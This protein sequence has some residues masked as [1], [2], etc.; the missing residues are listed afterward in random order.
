[1]FFYNSSDD[2]EDELECKEDSCS[3]T[4]ACIK[5]DIYALVDVLLEN[6][7]MER[8]LI[9]GLISTIPSQLLLTHT[10]NVL[11]HDKVD[12]TPTIPNDDTFKTFIEVF[13]Q[14]VIPIPSPVCDRMYTVYNQLDTEHK[15]AA[16]VALKN[17]YTRLPS[18]N[19]YD[20]DE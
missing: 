14:S 4:Q 20:E 13:S 16:W 6:H 2:E 8:V 7:L 15:H 19:T 9:C 1:M 10:R 5:S 12:L 17:L 11:N 18:L 3:V